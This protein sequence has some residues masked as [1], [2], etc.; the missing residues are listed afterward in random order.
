MIYN[1][2]ESKTTFKELGLE[3]SILEA[4]E[5]LNFVH[6][7]EIQE[8]AIPAMLANDKDV[9]GIAQTG[10][11]KTAAF[12]LP[13]IQ[14]LDMGMDAPQALI[15]SPTRELCIQICRDI[16]TYAKK[17]K[18]V[19]TLAVYGG[20]DIRSQIKSLQK[21]VNI[22]VGTPGRTLDLI[23]RRRLNLTEIQ[24]LVL[25]EA[26]EML[27]MGFKES[28]TEILSTTPA[29]K[30]T[31]LFSATMPKDI[32]KISKTYMSDPLEI[33][34]TQEN[35]SAKNVKHIYYTINPR[36]RYKALKRLVDFH[37][38]V[39]GIIFCRTK[40]ETQEVAIKLGSDGYNSDA[41][42][43]DLSQAQRDQVMGR[44]RSGQIK[45]LVATDVAARGIDV[46]DLT[47]VINFNLPDSLET[48]VHRSGR[49]GRA[50]KSG[51]SLILVGDKEAYRIR[52][53]E[54]LLD[55]KIERGSIPSEAE[56][57]KRR[58]FAE[59]EKIEKIVVADPSDLGP[60]LEEVKAKLS[61]MTK[62]DLIERWISSEFATT[63][64]NIARNEN[65]NVEV[66]ENRGRG[67]RDRGRGRD[68]DSNSRK[69]GFSRDAKGPFTR[70][71]INLGHNDRVL[72]KELI[73][74]INQNTRG[75]SIQLGRIDID[76]SSSYV[77]VDASQ[78]KDLLKAF[79]D[80]KFK[81][82][83]VLLQAAKSTKK[84]HYK[85]YKKR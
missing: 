50:N 39:Y 29:S 69:G 16:K 7:T 38:E 30:R 35:T 34:V 56:V 17:K 22:V 48:Y 71:S 9:V 4:L 54:R 19:T 80:V 8:R 37:P 65:L 26:D 72:P 43:G 84:P 2:L 70:V 51:D 52:H 83:K 46:S 75:K 79:K 14:M 58:I 44:F 42:H 13:I 81:G 5:D 40:R 57:S 11:G 59:V 1:D 76:R 66:R 63:L 47:H 21:G 73:G 23:N 33:S 27:S 64:K 53:L 49:T 41:I 15:L 10:T 20:S 45:L 60:I 77:D 6:P 3:D 36:Q 32:K 85:K 82:N 62:D 28:L 31:I 78:V 68:G 61:W 18:G 55:A 67:D 25:D 12:S 24:W 74:L